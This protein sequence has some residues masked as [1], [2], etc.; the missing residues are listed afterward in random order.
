MSKLLTSI[1]MKIIESE[2]T[3]KFI[4]KLP[5]LVFLKITIIFV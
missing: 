3:S 5:T 2:V 1:T 4:P